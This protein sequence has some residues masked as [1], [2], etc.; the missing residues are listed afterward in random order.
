LASSGTLLV[1]DD[2]G[3]TWNPRGNVTEWSAL[4]VSADGNTLLTGGQEI[5]VSRDARV[6]RTTV[7]NPGNYVVATSC[8]GD[9]RQMIA[10]NHDGLRHQSSDGGLTWTIESTGVRW[11]A[12]AYASAGDRLLVAPYD[13]RLQTSASWT[14]A[15]AT[16]GISGALFD[17]IELQYVGG[18]RFTVLSHEGVLS[19][20]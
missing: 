15:G 1:S 12:A 7:D 16:G 8:S 2:G 11:V 4:A 13:G 5:H 19:V 14:T 20:Q 10:L 3:T 9:G 18:D 17:A 6:S